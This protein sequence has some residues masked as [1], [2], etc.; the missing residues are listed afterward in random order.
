M[1]PNTG[2]E[3]VVTQDISEKKLIA[4]TP[5]IVLNYELEGNL[6]GDP[7]LIFRIKFQDGREL[8]VESMYVQNRKEFI[9][10]TMCDIAMLKERLRVAGAP[11]SSEY[12]GVDLDVEDYEIWQK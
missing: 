12:Q 10:K 6:F 2:D 7:L 4:G 8:L 9:D 3:V 5:G 11:L 1:L